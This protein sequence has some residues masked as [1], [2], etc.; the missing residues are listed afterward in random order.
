M[1][2][3]AESM[4]AETL[5]RQA[6]FGESRGVGILRTFQGQYARFFASTALEQDL[7]VQI[8]DESRHARSYARMLAARNTAPVGLAG[9]APGWQ[10]IVCHIA[11]ANS[12]STTLVGLYGLME[13][14]NLLAMNTLLPLLDKADLADV[15]QIARDEAR[16]IGMFDVFAELVERGVLRVDV[17]EGAEMIR[18][19]C[20]A[21]KDGIALPTGEPVTL[22]RSDWRGFMKH[23]GQLQDRMLSWR[24][25]AA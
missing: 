17:A 5:M 14:F 21:L 18:V 22:P 25:A 6:F 24:D 1:S 11:Q 9:V 20:D 12:F 4:L 23:V 2:T 16:H 13:P 15:D 7:R 10:R 3:P 19:F 8:A